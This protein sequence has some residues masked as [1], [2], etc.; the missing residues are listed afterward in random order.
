MTTPVYYPFYYG[1]NVVFRERVVY[2]DNVR[3][4]NVYVYVNDERH[5]T[6]TEFY[7]QAWDLAH[8]VAPTPA[9]EVAQTAD[10]WLV[11]GTF[12]IFANSGETDTGQ[13]IQLAASN[14]GEFRGNLVDEANDEVWQIYGALDPETQRVALRFEGDD[15]LV[16]ECGLWNLTQET[17]PLLIHHGEE[18][19]EVL[20]LIRLTQQEE[21]LAP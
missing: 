7:R 6:A 18:N 8:S 14:A 10:D 12:A 4:Q 11:M 2:V 3:Y 13:I 15:Y 5:S 16:L 9:V 20:T 17:L 1:T 19:S 21:L